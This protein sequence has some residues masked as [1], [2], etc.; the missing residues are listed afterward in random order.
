MFV[1]ASVVEIPPEVKSPDVIVI[2]QNKMPL[3]CFELS[4]LAKFL[5]EK[6]VTRPRK[7]SCRRRYLRVDLTTISLFVV[8]LLVTKCIDEHDLRRGIAGGEEG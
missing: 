4:P 5:R 2:F 6:L 3:P 7:S 8:L 1:L